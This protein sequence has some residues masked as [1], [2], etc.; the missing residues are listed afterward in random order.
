MRRSFVMIRVDS[1]ALFPWY[2][3]EVT[4]TFEKS[5]NDT[6]KLTR[7]FGVNPMSHVHSHKHRV[8]KELPDL[9]DVFILDVPRLLADQEQGRILKRPVRENSLGDPVIV[10]G[11]DG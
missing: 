3:R 8:R 10:A 4:L 9:R 2:F 6:H 5:G 1:R 11:K 7:R